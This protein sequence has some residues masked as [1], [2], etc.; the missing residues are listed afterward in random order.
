MKR[1]AILLIALI[2]ISTMPYS[3]DML[4][5]PDNKLSSGASN[6]IRDKCTLTYGT[7]N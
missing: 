2:L 7:Y 5:N 4:L 1:K 6:A 3:P